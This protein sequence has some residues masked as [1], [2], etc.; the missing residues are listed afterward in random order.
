M[1]VMIHFFLSRQHEA[2]LK[3]RLEDAGYD[4]AKA[5]GAERR[6]NGLPLARAPGPEGTGLSTER[7]IN[8]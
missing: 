1:S 2:S 5:A 3:Q 7:R 4:E 6:G 8:R